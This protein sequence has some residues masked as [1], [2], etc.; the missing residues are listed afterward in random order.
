MNS[1]V[2]AMSGGV[3]SSITAYLF[4]EMGYR[5]TGV[6]F[7][8]FNISWYG[9]TVLKRYQAN[10]ERAKKVADLLGIPFMVKDVSEQFY[11]SVVEPF[12]KSYISGYTPNPCVFCNPLIKMEAL[13]EIANEVGSDLYATGHYA[14]I[15]EKDGKFFV[16]TSTH[17]EKDQSYFLYRLTQEHLKQLKLPLGTRIKSD[18]KKFVRKVFPE[19]EFTEESQE[20]CFIADN[21]KNFL[22]NTFRIKET[23]GE[24]VDKDGKVLG[25]HRGIAFYTV[26]QRKGLG[27]ATGKPLYVIRIEPES[28]RIVVGEKNDLYPEKIELKALTFSAGSPLSRKFKCYV[29]ARYRM[30]PVKAEVTI[31]NEDRA[32]VRFLE[33]CAFPAPGQ[34][35]VFYDKEIVIGGGIIEKWL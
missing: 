4:K 35:A 25:T 6:N 26:G 30:Q 9:E 29:K 8:L 12:V 2:V 15:V 13:K 34:S 32:I 23:P 20:I 14:R 21:Y 31:I 18:I 33:P 11:K 19:I 1:V 7:Q 22:K 16:A 27:I 28:N 3:D 17:K 24:I 5:V 10:L